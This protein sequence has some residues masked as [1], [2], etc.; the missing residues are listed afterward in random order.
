MQPL[1]IIWWFLTNAIS[2]VL[3]VVVQ[4]FITIVQAYDEGMLEIDR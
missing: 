3:W 2:Y 4:I 1:K